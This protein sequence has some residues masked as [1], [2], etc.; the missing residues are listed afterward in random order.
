MGK[1]A[2]I[3]LHC[4]LPEAMEGPTPVSALIHAAT[5]VTAGIF[6]VL[7]C[8]FFFQACS[9][10]LSLLFFFG[11]LTVFF[12]TIVGLSQFDIKKVIAYSTCSQLGYMLVACACSNYKLAIFHLVNHAFIKALLFL[13]AGVIISQLGGEQDV[14]RMGGLLHILPLTYLFMAVGSFSL[15]GF[16]FLSGYY[17]KDLIIEYTTFKITF[18]HELVFWVISVSA[19]LT[20]FYSFRLLFLVFFVKTNV[21]FTIFFKIR[22]MSKMVAAPLFFLFILS[23]FSGYFLFDFF[24]GFGNEIF[25]GIL[26]TQKSEQSIDVEDLSIFIKLLPSF[27][28]FLGFLFGINYDRVFGFTN[29]IVLAKKINCSFFLDSFFN[30][31]FVISVLRFSLICCFRLVDKLLLELIGPK[32]IFF[33]TKGIFLNLNSVVFGRVDRLI[34][35]SLYLVFLLFLLVC[36]TF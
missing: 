11:G 23:I 5:M 2:Q 18:A 31:F 30:S 24:L 17:S 1:S 16:P 3:G 13:T 19:F 27:L 21:P 35:L 8:S 10:I 22:E 12:G 25:A 4:W 32:G 15:I 33:M 36:F 9:N 28:S 7:R 34:F 26:P 14:R 20:A 29:S 6:L